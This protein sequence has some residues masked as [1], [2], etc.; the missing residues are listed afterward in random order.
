M[1]QAFFRILSLFG[2]SLSAALSFGIV[3]A[4]ATQDEVIAEGKQEYQE[5]CTACHG[6]AGKGDGRM[7]ELLI[8]KPADLTQVAKR[9]GGAFPF[10]DIYKII[11]GEQPTKGHLS[12]PMPVWESRFKAD[13]SK[14]GYPP[15]YMR[16]L[17]LTHY[18][19]SI[20]EK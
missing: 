16:I 12:Y 13:E 15:A 10:W 7:A 11:D 5:N 1:R 17:S 20:Q 8:V 14:P 2:L 9:R 18:L 4:L 19:E 6:D 3:P